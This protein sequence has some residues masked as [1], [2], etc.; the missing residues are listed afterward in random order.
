M[1]LKPLLACIFARSPYVHNPHTWSDPYGLALAY[2]GK[3]RNLGLS[4]AAQKALEKFEKIKQGPLGDI[5]STPH[6]N[7]CDAV[8]REANDEVMAR[9][10]DGAPFDHIADLT[11]AGLPARWSGV[12]EGGGMRCLPPAVQE[13]LRLRVVSALESG[14]V[15]TYGQAAK[16]FGISERSV[17]TWWRAGRTGGRQ[18]LLAA[19]PEPPAGKGELIDESARGTA[20]QAMRDH[21]PADLGQNG[22]MWTGTSVRTRVRPVCGVS[23]AERG[24][25]KLS[26]CLDLITDPSLEAVEDRKPA[27]LARLRETHRALR[28]QREDRHRV[29]VLLSL[30][31]NLVEDYGNP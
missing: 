27:A 17:G 16:M 24:V 1:E 18:G 13:D 14:R 19:V 9:K 30:I 25:G 15:R 26:A 20:L 5:N 21:T 8:R 31:G 6:R 29:D 22:A 11:Q 4:D 28:A 12:I 10:P 2:E 7:H 3:G 23:T